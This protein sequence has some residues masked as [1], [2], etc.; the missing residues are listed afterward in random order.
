M[1]IGSS[2]DKQ[3]KLQRRQAKCHKTTRKI[4]MGVIGLNTKNSGHFFVAINKF[5]Y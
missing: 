5:V 2:G 1:P 3:A 4:G